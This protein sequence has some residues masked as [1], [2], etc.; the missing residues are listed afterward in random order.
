MIF[1]KR[2]GWSVVAAFV[3]FFAIFPGVDSNAADKALTFSGKTLDGSE[4]TLDE[5]L[6]K[7]PIL[8]DFGSIYCSSCISSLPFLIKLQNRYGPDKIRVVGI[9]LDRGLARVRRFYSQYK[10]NL[11][12][13][14]IVEDSISI[15]LSYEVSTLPSYIIIDAKGNI[16]ETFVGYTDETVNEID[17]GV[18]A[19]INKAESGAI[20]PTASQPAMTLLTPDSFTKTYQS[21]I[22]VVGLTRGDVGPYKLLLNGGSEKQAMAND[23]MFWV[24]TPLSLGSNYIEIK[25]EGTETIQAVVLFRDPLMGPS[26]AEAFT[27]F[28]FHSPANEKKCSSCHEMQMEG[29]AE[30]GSITTFCLRCHGYLTEHAWVHGPIPVGGCSPCHD[31]NSRPH[32]YDILYQGS[33][34][35]FTCHEDIRDKFARKNIHGPVAIGLCIACHSPHSSPF[36]YQLVDTAGE[37]CMSCHE[38]IREIYN[39]KLVLHKPFKDGRCPACHDP[40]SSDSPKYFLKGEGDALCRR[41]HTEEKMTT[42]KHPVGRTPKFVADGMRLGPKGLLECLTCHDPHG[43]DNPRMHRISQNCGCH[44]QQ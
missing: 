38:A 19:V 31:F 44:D 9:N 14:I 10:D 15:S 41:C 22:T 7:R 18:K 43:T 36:K 20:K 35:C 25:K 30:L 33:D 3:L 8:I 28:K 2:R 6:G 40:H 27:E 32:R 42:H 16:F 11:N 5:H 39:S 29:G 13:P 1:K 4:F 26:M 34:L 12:F 37:L 21:S 24:R 23:K 17:E